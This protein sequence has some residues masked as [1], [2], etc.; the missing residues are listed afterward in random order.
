MYYVLFHI[1]YFYFS[2]P[3]PLASSSFCTVKNMVNIKK[4][5][6]RMNAESVFLDLKEWVGLLQ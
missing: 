3:M 2:R 4:K 1:A 5:V 6:C